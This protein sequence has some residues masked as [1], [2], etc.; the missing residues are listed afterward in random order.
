METL[1]I[2]A[3]RNDPPPRAQQSPIGKGTIKPYVTLMVH[4]LLALRR[5]RPLY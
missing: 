4:A 2:S 3:Y 1:L 5:E